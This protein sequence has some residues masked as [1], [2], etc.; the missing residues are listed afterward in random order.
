MDKLILAIEDEYDIREILE[1]LLTDSGYKVVTFS[2]GEDVVNKINQIH[3]D[4]ILLDI[5]LGNFDGRE[6]CRE[7]K[8]N[9]ETKNIP[10][11]MVSA[12]PDIENTLVEFGADDFIP[13]PF[14]IYNLLSR[15]E[16]QL[17]A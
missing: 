15:V 13:K 8:R 16:R 10:V 3:P 5:M 6:I 11:I 12:H 9:A 7:I 4:L 17:A 1:F 2:T 14:D